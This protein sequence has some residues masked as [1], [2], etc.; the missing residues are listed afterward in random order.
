MYLFYVQNHSFH[1]FL[2][3]ITPSFFLWLVQSTCIFCLHYILNFSC[4]DP[5]LSGSKVH[6]VHLVC[7]PFI[8]NTCCLSASTLLFFL[9]FPLELFKL[10]SSVTLEVF[11]SGLISL[12]QLT[13]LVASGPTI[14]DCTPAFLTLPNSEYSDPHIF[15]LKDLLYLLFS[16]LVDVITR[17]SLALCVNAHHCL[18]GPCSLIWNIYSHL[19]RTSEG[20]FLSSLVHL[21]TLLPE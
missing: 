9:T 11:H 12:Q 15:L 5:S 18:Q 14:N 19:K 6:W 4:W 20:S 3:E 7:Q 16:S 13:L 1:S 2:T 17:S 10:R 8:P 21:S